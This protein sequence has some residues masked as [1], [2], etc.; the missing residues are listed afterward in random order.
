MR[1]EFIEISDELFL[2]VGKMITERYGIRM[3][4]E[5]KIMFQSRLQRRLRELDIHSFDD[6][7]VRLFGVD[8][9][10]DE[11]N[12]LADFISTN[13]TE[14]FREKDHFQFL[15]SHLL[16]EYLKKKASNPNLFASNEIVE[17][18]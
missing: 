12:L 6:Y 4:L 11:V 10:A 9:E 16:P 17:C 14:F 18:R 2:Q 8:N 13:K 3:P 1:S 15:E 7:V 5:K